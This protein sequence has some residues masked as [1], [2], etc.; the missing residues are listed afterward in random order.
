MGEIPGFGSHEGK[1]ELLV[2][3][4]GFEGNRSL[5][6]LNEITPYKTITINGFPSYLLDY[7]DQSIILNRDFLFQSGCKKAI[8]RASASDPF[9][10][11]EVLET[12]LKEH[13]G[14]LLTIAPLGS[15][16]MALGSLIFL[17]EHPDSSR[18]VFSYPQ[19]YVS[20]DQ[21]AQKYGKTWFYRL[22]N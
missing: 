22:K 4:L 21:P 16:P 13:P 9:E 10:T 7:K 2:I 1:K 11:Y 19:E 5:E 12:I 3:L 18:A 6:I 20:K 8:K 15:K 17:L 14:Y